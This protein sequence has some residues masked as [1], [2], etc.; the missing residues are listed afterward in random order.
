MESDSYNADSIVV[1]SALEG[2]RRRPGMYIGGV[3]AEGLHHMLWE[4]VGNAVDEHLRGHASYVRVTIDGAAISVEDDG[5][6]IP[7]DPVPDEPALSVLELVLTRL[8]AGSGYR[9]DH[10]HLCTN[11]YGVGAAAVTA[12]SERLDAEVWRDGRHY[13]QSFA[14]GVALGPVRDLGPADRTGTRITFVPDF[15]ILENTAWNRSAIKRRLR[16]IAAAQPRLTAIL[17]HSAVRY[18]GGMVDHVRYLARNRRLLAAPLGISGVR[19]DVA[20][21]VALAWTDAPRG[22]VRGFVGMSRARRGTHVRGLAD[23]LR[24]AFAA[25]DPARFATVYPA[26]FAEVIDPGL[27]A[28]VNVM[29]AHP[30][31]GSPTRDHLTNPEVRAAVAA[32]VAEALHGR[33]V[34]D[35]GLREVLLARMA[36]W[37]PAPMS[38]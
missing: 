34:S 4:I 20:I 17:D 25:L 29:L 13:Q 23:G 9:R 37:S 35:R 24:G 14:R 2:I 8:H 10:V 22:D 18:P 6:G 31:F 38:A 12:L 19:D 11:L 7:V 32:T 30:R 15:T 27:I 3:G 5:R 33:L 26:A 36:P 21:E 28:V 16:E 1:I